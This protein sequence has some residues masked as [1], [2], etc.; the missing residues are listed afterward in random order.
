ML[1]NDSY[2]LLYHLST[3]NYRNLNLNPCYW[4]SMYMRLLCQC[5]ICIQEH[6]HRH[7]HRHR[8]RHWSTLIKRTS[9]H[10]YFAQV[11]ARVWVRVWVRVRASSWWRLNCIHVVVHV[12][13]RTTRPR[14]C[15]SLTLNINTCTSHI[16]C[17]ATCSR[18][19][20]TVTSTDMP[21]LS[22]CRS[23]KHACSTCRTCIWWPWP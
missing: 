13:R 6:W 23:S 14:L 2:Q 18:S 20:A 8:H 7:R 12:L 17:N 10:W 21:N 11:R 4:E 1:L 5:M 3:I 19:S 9:K 15:T 22:T 16:T